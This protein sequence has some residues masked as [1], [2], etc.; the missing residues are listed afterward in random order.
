MKI[1][2]F[3]SN[4]VN[5]GAYI[6][7]EGTVNLNFENDINNPSEVLK[8]L[9]KDYHTYISE[10]DGRGYKVCY[11]LDYSRFKG[12][13]DHPGRFK[14]T[15]DYL[16]DGKI[17]DGEQAVYD[18]LSQS[19]SVYDIE[20]VDYII[21][22]ESS[23]GLNQ[24]MANA[25]NRV[26]PNAKIIKLKKLEFEN[27][28]L[29]INWKELENQVDRQSINTAHRFMNEVASMLERNP[30]FPSFNPNQM[31]KLITQCDTVDEIK[32]VFEESLEK[33][34]WKEVHRD[35]KPLV[36]FKMRSSGFL[37]RDGLRDFFYPKYDFKTNDYS[38]A[39]IDCI[40][41]GNKKM[42][43]IDDNINTGI[44]TE[45]IAKD[46]DNAALELERTDLNYRDNFTFYVLYSMSDKKYTTEPDFTYRIKGNPGYYNKIGKTPNFIQSFESFIR[47][48]GDLTQLD[49]SK[50]SV[51]Q[52]TSKRLANYDRLRDAEARKKEIYTSET[53]RKI[54]NVLGTVRS[55]FGKDML[56]VFTDE[57]MKY[58]NR[59][60]K[61]RSQV[62]LI[63]EISNATGETQA[64][65]NAVYYKELKDI[66]QHN[67]PELW[68]FGRPFPH[69]L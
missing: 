16:K 64:F 41:D 40:M 61:L 17:K 55:E 65:I 66:D 21:I 67:N 10:E 37:S 14:A 53:S 1:K 28:G 26:F 44:D 13:V 59:D 62:N 2:R 29:A 27:P 32:K 5:E 50:L 54:E 12:T 18:F 20:D 69:Q 39:V 38:N 23:K 8:T 49:V 25:T 58:N 45:G 46:I 68:P 35:G 60:E 56:S 3:K 4:A 33:L 15:M 11:G 48:T 63:K 19:Y 42:L 30:D 6:D 31:K 9:I 51:D 47:D 34:K 7:D 24:Y 22:T 43:F 36:P 57:L 52:S